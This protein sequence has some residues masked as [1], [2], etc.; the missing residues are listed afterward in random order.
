MLVFFLSPFYGSKKIMTPKKIDTDSLV[1]I[2]QP[3]LQN[4][5]KDSVSILWK[6]SV[7]DNCYIKYGI[8]YPLTSKQT[9]KIILHKIGNSKT[10]NIIE[11]VEDNG[12]IK[13][14]YTYPDSINT[15]MNE[16]T[17]NGLKRGQKYY[18]E[19]YTND[20]KLVS[21][22]EYYFITE[23]E[24]NSAF[25]FYAMGDIGESSKKSGFQDVTARQ[26][27]YLKNK[28]NFGIGLGD[29]VYKDGESEWYDE[30]F[31]NP[32][33]PVLKNI[34]FYPALGN[35]DWNKDPGENFT[36]EWKLPNNEHY[37]S[38]NYS[39]AHFIA[40]DSWNGDLYEKEKQVAWLENNLKN[41]Q[42]KYDWILVYLHHNGKTCTYK[43]EYKQVS[44][45]YSL[46]AKYNVDLVLN[47][48]AHTYERLHPFDGNGNVIESYRANTKIYP[49][50]KNG[51]IAI[52]TG[53][54]GKL[55]KRWRPIKCD[56]NIVAKAE[57]RGHFCVIEIEG[58]KLKLRAYASINGD[59]FDEFSIDKTIK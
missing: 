50:I 58:K 21:G 45:L 27:S 3:Y 48:H 4:V 33:L 11:V 16:V 41:A 43:K 31:F 22:K 55:K 57:H 53:A 46:F 35:H 42:N 36:K 40:L 32:M 5:F 19:V 56:E 44:E 12:D 26:I 30:Y 23:K 28:P 38:F 13:H 8:S 9:G 18:Y 51:F 10:A 20:E 47:G 15:Y 17:I 6:T 37:Y 39:N 59:M 14:Y 1:L 24:N 25:S 54:G 52:T 29:I 34:P 49:E 2:R 7:A